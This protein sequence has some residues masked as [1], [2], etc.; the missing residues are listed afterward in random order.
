MPFGLCNALASFQRLMNKV[1][2]INISKFIATH[3][4]DILVFSW[5]LDEHCQHLRWALEQIRKTNLNGRLHKCEFL[6]D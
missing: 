6:K 4:D 2:A 5:N 1:F 3:L